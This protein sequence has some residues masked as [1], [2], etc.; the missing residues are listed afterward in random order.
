[1]QQMEARGIQLGPYLDH[2]MI[3]EIHQAL[4]VQPSGGGGA[5][6]GERFG[7]EEDVGEEI[8]ED[9]EVE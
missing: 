7:D 6:G 2:A 1:M 5:G 3:T 4:G 8:D 9:E